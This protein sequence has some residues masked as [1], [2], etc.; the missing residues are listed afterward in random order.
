M[1][2]KLFTG[3]FDSALTTVI[4]VPHFLLCIGV[5]L[6]LG[7]ILTFGHIY[8]TAYGIAECYL[9]LAFFAWGLIFGAYLIFET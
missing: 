5:S 9:L 7:I 4:S 2:D 1:F 8:R 3:L 6:I